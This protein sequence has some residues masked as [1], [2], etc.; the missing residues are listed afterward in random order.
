MQSESESDR[1]R[2]RGLLTRGDREALRD[3]IDEE[4]LHDLRWNVRKRM[5]R[6]EEDLEILEEAGEEELVDEFY[7]EFGVGDLARRVRE[8]EKGV[9]DGDSR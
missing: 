6:I 9:N 7:D 3:G 8:L 2:N 5:E 1:M 4:K